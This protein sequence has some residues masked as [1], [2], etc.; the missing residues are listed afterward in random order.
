MPGGGLYRFNDE[1]ANFGA[2]FGTTLGAGLQ[3]LIS[4]KVQQK[5][6]HQ[7]RQRVGQ[8]LLGL[9]LSP[10]LAN[11]PTPLLDEVVKAKTKAS[12]QAPSLAPGIRTLMPDLSPE[13]ASQVG[14]LSPGLQQLFYRNYL[15]SG[16]GSPDQN[17]QQGLR[18]TLAGLNIP[19]V[20]QP[21]PQLIQQ[22]QPQSALPPEPAISTPAIKGLRKPSTAAVGKQLQ[23]AQAPIVSAPVAPLAPAEKPKTVAER[24]QEGRLK[25]QEKKINIETQKAESKERARLDKIYKP[26]V[27][28]QIKA[29][30]A[31]IDGDKRL[32]RMRTLINKGTLPS[33]FLYS[34]FKGIEDAF[35][36]LPFVGQGL[37]ALVAPMANLLGGKFST[38]NPKDI[39][40][41]EK[42][43]QDFTKGA[44]DIFG[45]RITNFDLENFLKMIP[46][47]S[48]TDQGK[49][50]IAEN[51]KSFNDAIHAKTDAMKQI[52]ASNG[53][54]IPDNLEL[55]IEEVA[56]PRLDEIA[57]K[58]RLGYGSYDVGVDESKLPPADKAVI[59]AQLT[60]K[61]VKYINIQTPNGQKWVPIPK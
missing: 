56:K 50:A 52:I 3:A 15:E 27:Q 13:E 10:E 60:K 18:Q 7:E 40:E 55:L 49:L 4:H 24:I 12:Y 53:G 34:S 47:L 20:A 43:S 39:E 33:G 36:A 5:L 48:Q 44:K 59:G 37:G 1:P 16:L 54:K 2:Q 45:A 32:A 6:Q 14:A 61:G 11:L 29:D 57:E 26:L 9:G 58:M 23:Q 8:A 22:Q 25:Q 19:E 46:T 41:F 31:A 38:G 17:Q 35:R 21:S 28:A 51:M 30:S 42:L